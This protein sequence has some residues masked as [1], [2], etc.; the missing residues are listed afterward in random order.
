MIQ[1]L[2]QHTAVFFSLLFAHSHA[3]FA[4]AHDL[5]I[6]TEHFQKGNFGISAEYCSEATSGFF[7]AS[8]PQIEIYAATV[9]SG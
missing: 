7:T 4:S 1:N 2:R 3:V 5:T 9:V 6:C 8:D